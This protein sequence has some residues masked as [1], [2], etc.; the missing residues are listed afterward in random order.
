MATACGKCRSKHIEEDY[1]P[2]IGNVGLICRHCGQTGR[3][4]WRTGRTAGSRGRLSVSEPIGAKEREADMPKD[5]LKP[6]AG[7]GAKKICKKCNERETMS[8]NSPYCARCLGDMGRAK[9]EKKQPL[10]GEGLAAMKEDSSPSGKTRP[11][12]IAAVT[13]DFGNHSVLLET[14]QTLA[15]EEIRPVDMQI[16]YLLKTRVSEIKKAAL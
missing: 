9:K 14:I 6:G 3:E 2:G 10:G 11:G 16:I 13:V 8:E 7:A 4:G 12:A 1:V 15:S 5:Q